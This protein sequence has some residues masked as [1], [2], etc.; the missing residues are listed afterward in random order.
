MGGMDGVR[1]LL[2]E[3]DPAAQAL[4]EAFFQKAEG[5]CL[6]G[7][8]RNGEAGLEAIRCLHPHV[9]LLDLVLPR[10]S[11]VGLLRALTD[12]MPELRPRILVL[13]RVNSQTIIQRCM[14]LGADFYLL[15]PVN[16]TELEE[17]IRTL[18]APSHVEDPAVR[19]IRAMG[20]NP[21]SLGCRYAAIVARTLAEN[22]GY[23]QLKAGYYRAAELEHTSYACVEKNIRAMIEKLYRADMPAWRSLWEEPQE[24]RPSNGAFLRRLARRLQDGE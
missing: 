8:A 1:V 18:G 20:G 5:M 16:L 13:S 21:D 12:E 23:L 7:I 22:V 9:V 11:G 3:D 19:L 15:K 6:V 4:M 24:R 14:E 17:L 2:V 10:L